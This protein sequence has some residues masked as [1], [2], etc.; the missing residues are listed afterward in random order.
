MKKTVFKK[1][2]RKLYT[3]IESIYKGF[4]IISLNDNI[5]PGVFCETAK[6]YNFVKCCEFLW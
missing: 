4:E 3:F 5:S 1:V 6:K 2:K